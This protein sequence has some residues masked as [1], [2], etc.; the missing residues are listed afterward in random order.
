MGGGE[1]YIGGYETASD[2]SYAMLD[3]GTRPYSK[4]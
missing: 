3:D 2:G 4:G 1:G